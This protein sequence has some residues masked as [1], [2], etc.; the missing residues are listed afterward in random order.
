MKILF[1]YYLPSGGM[2]TLNRQRCLALQK[3]GITCHLLYFKNGAGNHNIKNIP[4]FITNDDHQIQQII[5]KENYTLVVVS[6]D[7]LFLKKLR[8]FG[9]KGKII[10]EVQG[11]GEE[12]YVNQILQSIKSHITPYANGLLY[13]NTSHLKKYFQQHYPTL[14]QYY[15]HNCIDT[16]TFCYR[17]LTRQPSPIIGWVGRLEKNKNWEGFLT[18]CHQLMK[19]NPSIKIWMF[20]DPTLATPEETDR[21]NKMVNDLQL[22]NN[23]TTY[24]NISHDQMANYYSMIGDSKG[25]L[26]ST[27][28]TEGF[29]YAVLEAMACRC[30]VLSTDSDGVRSFII[31]NKTG[32]YFKNTTDAVNQAKQIINDAKLREMIRTNAQKH[33]QIYFHPSQYAQNFLKLIKE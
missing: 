20:H 12:K 32:K 30:P 17:S 16:N 6:S 4:T 29:G 15:F 7:Y 5:K 31:H 22:K 21:Y 11:L 25:F 18:I 1:V 19:N 8:D 26:C 10:Y 2:E 9:Y 28:I 14:K 27:S 23:L 13:P 24:S 3:K 33:I